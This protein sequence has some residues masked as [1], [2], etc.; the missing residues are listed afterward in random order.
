ML[1]LNDPKQILAGKVLKQK[2][3]R[4]LVSESFKQLHDEIKLLPLILFH[5]QFEHS[6]FIFNV[7]DALR[8]VYTELVDSL[9]RP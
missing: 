8:V 6:F 2:A 1:I 5:Q 7:F 3:H 9:Q 4:L